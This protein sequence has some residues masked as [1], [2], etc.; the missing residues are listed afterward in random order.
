MMMMIL[1]SIEM[2]DCDGD[3]DFDGDGD[4]DVGDDGDDDDDDEWWCR[5]CWWMTRGFIV[6][7]RSW[8]LDNVNI[9]PAPLQISDSGK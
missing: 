5:G 1:L 3:D 2:E 6:D 8:V 4:D 9:L 7:E